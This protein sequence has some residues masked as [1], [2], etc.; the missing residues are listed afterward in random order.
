MQVKVIMPPRDGIMRSPP[1]AE[2][3]GEMWFGI[4]FSAIQE[5]VMLWNNFIRIAL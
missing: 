5:F 2:P 1:P 3:L 4:T